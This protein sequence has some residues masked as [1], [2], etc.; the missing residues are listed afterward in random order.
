V[1]SFSTT[2][3]FIETMFA[4]VW[5][6]VLSR[7]SGNE[8]ADEG[9]DEPIVIGVEPNE[10]FT[11]ARTLARHASSRC[12]EALENLAEPPVT[13]CSEDDRRVFIEHD[14]QA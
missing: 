7:V 10:R 9:R 8:P 4:R 5:P 6:R 1:A 12:A 14:R 3:P 13:I 11:T 2:F